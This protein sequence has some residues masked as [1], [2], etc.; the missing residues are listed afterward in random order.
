MK[1][2]AFLFAVLFLSAGCFKQPITTEQS[3]EDRTLQGTVQEKENASLTLPIADASSRVTKKGFGLYVTPENSPVDPEKFKGYHVGVDY[4][5]TQ[6]EKHAEI[7]IYAICDG[8]VQLSKF[9]SGYGGL[10]IQSCF[11]NN[12]EATVLYGHLEI[13]S[14]QNKV[15][16]TLK[17]GSL[18]G[19]LGQAG[20]RD[21]DGERKHLHLGVHKGGVID[22]RG[23]VQSQSEIL[24]W[25]DY[26]KVK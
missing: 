10:L 11:L 17:R 15:G 22:L 3:V 24:N 23:Y 2:K 25:L 12:Q 6:S 7:S 16:L 5:T 18:V 19:V 13:S 20:S 4:E 9:V 8:K 21:T 14:I 1:T 26:E